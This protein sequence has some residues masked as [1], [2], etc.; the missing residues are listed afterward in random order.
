M[1]S[2]SI[3][4]IDV[5]SAG[6]KVREMG[7]GLRSVERRHRRPDSI[8][9][10]PCFS[11][12]MWKRCKGLVETAPTRREEAALSAGVASPPVPRKVVAPAPSCQARASYP[13]RVDCSHRHGLGHGLGQNWSGESMRRSSRSSGKG[14][15]THQLVWKPF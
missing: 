15:P 4:V 9:T 13:S 1:E 8:Q 7:S 10:T 14:G 6:C 11:L 3:R 12:G 2:A 5:E